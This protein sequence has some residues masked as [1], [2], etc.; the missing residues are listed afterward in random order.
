MGERRKDN[1]HLSTHQEIAHC[2]ARVMP[3][4][5]RDLLI[6][7]NRWRCLRKGAIWPDKK[8]KDFAYHY[9]DVDKGKFWAIDHLVNVVNDLS[10]IVDK[11][12]VGDSIISEK[13]LAF[14]FGVLSHYASDL[15]QPLHTASHPQ[16]KKIHSLMEREVMNNI[17]CMPFLFEKQDI[18]D[19]FGA[20]KQYCRSANNKYREILISY[21][22]GNGLPAY[23]PTIK[24]AYNDACNMVGNLFLY[25]WEK[26]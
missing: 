2:V 19:L 10:K 24:T 8:L 11:Y 17:D 14:K 18:Q 20:I 4:E 7:R 13:E 21:F 5:L 6:K 3:T 1:L 22:K 25:C 16:E 23:K 15:G 12:C 26:K 9:V